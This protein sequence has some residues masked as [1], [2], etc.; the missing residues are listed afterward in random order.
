MHDEDNAMKRTQQI[1]QQLRVFHVGD[2]WTGVNLQ[3]TLAGITWEQA[4]T[5]VKEFHTIAELVYHLNYF[6]EVTLKVIQGGTLDAKEALSFD[7]PRIAGPQ[8]WEHLLEKTW[9]DAE[10]LAQAIEQLPENQLKDPFVD[11]KW[12]NYYR[13]LQG[14]IEHGYYHLG[15]IAMLKKLLADKEREAVNDC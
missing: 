7:H 6:V 4:T 9:T 1:A 13:C 5:R 10:D 12:G 15:Q 11:V 3:D 2:N 8:D 14:P